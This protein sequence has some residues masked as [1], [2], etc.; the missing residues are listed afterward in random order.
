MAATIQV[1]LFRMR[2][3]RIYYKSYLEFLLKADLLTR[4]LALNPKEAAELLARVSGYD[5]HCTMPVGHECTVPFPSR[6]DLIIRLLTLRPDINAKRA[7]DIIIHLNLP[8]PVLKTS[9]ES[10]SP[11]TDSAHP[12]L[13]P[14]P[15]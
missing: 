12:F 5:N 15:H 9:P 1:P 2:G 14:R 3:M 11:Q 4:E 10:A 7:R 13:R 8:L 6:E